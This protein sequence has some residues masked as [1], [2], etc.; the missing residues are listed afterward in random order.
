MNPFDVETLRLQ[1][2]EQCYDETVLIVCMKS[3]IDDTMT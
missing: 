1:Y 2:R 3:C